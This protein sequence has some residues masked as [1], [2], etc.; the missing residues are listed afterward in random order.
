MTKQSTQLEKPTL[1]T[2]E[3]VL[4][5]DEKSRSGPAT[6]YAGA[7]EKTDPIEIALVK[8]LDMRIMPALWSMYFLNYLDR[9]SIASARLNGLEKDMGLE[10]NQYN[11]CISVLFV[12]YLLMQLPSNM[13]MASK[14]VRPSIYMGVC[15]ALWAIISACTALA[16]NY[17]HLVLTRFFLGVAE[18]PFYPGALYL[19]SI[20]YTRKEI[21]TRV[22]ILYTANILSTAFSG[23]IAAATF[24]TLDGAHGIKGWKWLFIIEGAI[25]F[26]VAILSVF[27]LPDH[28]LT[29]KW[30]TEEE[31]ILAHARMTQDTM[32]LQESKGVMEGFKQAFADPRLYL[33]AIMQNLHLS[34][35][36]FTNFF[37]TVVGTLGFNQT[38]TLILT[39]PPFLFAGIIG[40]LVAVSS[41]RFNE[42]TW[43]ITGGMGMAM[44]GFIMAA[45]TLNK[46]ARYVACF[47]FAAGA[48]SVNSCILGWVSATL[49]QTSEKKAVSLS[50][51]NIIANAS[52]V[53]TPY[54]YP[55]SNAPQ[56]LNAMS[57]N[58]A[59]SIGTVLCA[60]GLK[61]WLI[62]TNK[63]IALSEDG[64]ELRYAY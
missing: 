33:F 59:F 23:L 39:C 38:I 28:P 7:T 27:V 6:D 3:N 37:P 58:T 42:R 8:K 11:V 40:P 12:G 44:I 43:H 50:F 2:I 15:M 14:A 52:Y 25:T 63:K 9:S 10:G 20:F 21:T 36:G 5:D 24:A 45:S 16:T 17:Q 31:R 60:W 56:Y 46:G 54:L 30:L 57:A 1:H 26:A 34:A 19:L 47:L 55:S 29:T 51:V 48:Y 62:H 53:Y 49:G 32:G 61:A 41:G 35:C 13:L 4:A 22:A 18:A 64:N